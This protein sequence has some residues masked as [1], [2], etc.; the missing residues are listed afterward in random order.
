MNQLNHIRAAIKWEDMLFFSP[1]W[2]D[3]RGAT[4]HSS[5]GIQAINTEFCGLL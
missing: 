3:H 4:L 1:F 2:N 5:E